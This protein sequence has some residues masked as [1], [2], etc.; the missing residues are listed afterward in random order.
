M[1][2]RIEENP[3]AA[4][5]A[6][7]EL[8]ENPFYSE[9]RAN[10]LSQIQEIGKDT[11]ELYGIIHDFCL[12]KE[13][14]PITEQMKQ[15]ISQMQE[16]QFRG[17]LIVEY[18]DSSDCSPSVASKLLVQLRVLRKAMIVLSIAEPLFESYDPDFY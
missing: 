5:V 17:S 13:E 9:K 1:L 18:L 4:Y 3:E 6:A 7:S 10:N 2:K 8:I 15:R 11:V 14:L 16:A 12:S